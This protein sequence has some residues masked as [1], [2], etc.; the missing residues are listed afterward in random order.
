MDIEYLYATARQNEQIWRQFQ[1][2]ELDT[3]ACRHWQGLFDMLFVTLPN[4]MGFCAVELAFFDP[5]RRIQNS[6]L[7]Q[8]GT[9]DRY[10]ACLHFLPS[11]P[12]SLQSLHVLA[13]H[14][15][16][17]SRYASGMHL[18]LRKQKQI[19]GYLRLFAS[20]DHRFD[21]HSATDFI[22]HYSAILAAAVEL[23]LQTEEIERL[24]YEDPLTQVRNRRGMTQAFDAQLARSCRQEKPLGVVLLDLDHF[25]A[26]NDSHG[27]ATGDRTLVHFCAIAR[28]C[29]RPFDYLGRMGG[30][31]F[32]IILPDCDTQAVLRVVERLRQLVQQ[33][34]FFN[35]LQQPFNITV[36][37]GWGSVA[38]KEYSL[39]E[40][41]AKLDKAL[42]KAK[43]QGR[44]RINPVKF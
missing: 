4:R 29:L 23:V 37:G 7:R 40:V 26:I 14:E 24:A 3:L 11:L 25:K 20:A 15:L 36:S 17:L 43:Q 27:H 38:A 6:L 30:E 9:L 1:Q 31:E 16:A 33:T 28:S 12:A 19:F 5:N 32:L 34:Y 44:N 21:Q 2:L 13:A 35:D 10:R 22:E 18:P 8:L 39:E 42:Y 41:M